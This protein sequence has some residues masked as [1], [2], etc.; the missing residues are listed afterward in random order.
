MLGPLPCVLE[1][2]ICHPRV[3]LRSQAASETHGT[4]TTYN[5]RPAS[6]SFF[7]FRRGSGSRLG[8]S[9]QS[10][11]KEREKAPDRFYEI[12]NPNLGFS[13]PTTAWHRLEEERVVVKSEEEEKVR[14][15]PYRFDPC[16]RNGYFPRYRYLGRCLEQKVH[17]STKFTL[18]MA[19]WFPQKSQ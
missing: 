13:D 1:E 7:L 14:R 17:F 9:F 3:T 10:S 12:L 19:N 16:S 18:Y 15:P 6:S 2:V 4:T 11:V 8:S 5:D